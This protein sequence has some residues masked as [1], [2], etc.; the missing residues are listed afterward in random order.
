MNNGTAYAAAAARN[1]SLPPVDSALL[2]AEEARVL[3]DAIRWL[4]ERQ[5]EMITLHFLQE[6]SYA[7]IAG[8]L[9]VAVGT[10]KATIFS[11]K[12]ALRDALSPSAAEGRR[13]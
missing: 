4:P 3:I 6:L 7:E 12:I 11:A 13:E 10:V 5:R 2:E 1:H 8:A 9:G